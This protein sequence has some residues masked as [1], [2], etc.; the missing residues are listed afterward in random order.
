MRGGLLE[1][2]ERN[3]R[4]RSPE[5]GA[6][7]AAGHQEALRRV[8]RHILD[9]HP[10]LL[11]EARRR[12]EGRERLR[13]AIQNVI[14]AES[15]VV[16]KAAR[17][18][19]TEYILNEVTGLGPIEPLVQDEDITEIMVNG[20]Q[21]VWVETGGKMCRSSAC[22]KDQEQL[23]EVIA[24]AIAPLGR[25]IDQSVPFV[26][27]RLPDGSRLHACIPPVSLKGPILSIRKFPKTGF[28]LD[29]LVRL[30]SVG[31]ECAEFLRECVKVRLN[32]IV[33]GGT[34]SGKTSTLNALLS[35]VKNL[36]Q[37]VVTIEDCAELNPS[38]ENIVSLES[39]PANIEGKGEITIRMLVRN[40]LRT[41]P[42]RIV[43]G[44]VRG[45]EAFDMLQ[46]MNTGHQGSMSTVHANGSEDAL[47][48][49][50][51]MASL[52]PEVPDRVVRELIPAAVD[53]VIF[54]RRLPTGDRKLTAVSL[55]SKDANVRGPRLIPIFESPD[56]GDHA[57]LVRSP[58]VLPS[59]YGERAK[60]SMV[61]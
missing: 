11:G 24:R 8:Q 49:L 54:Q 46:A 43:I 12:E 14:A 27:G 57:D 5:P 58:H 15:L 35:E 32:I 42:D 29:D 4:Q 52:A 51:G 9:S 17:E 20:C 61:T 48:R 37:R 2:L 3:G 44:E 1:R 26:D 13:A 22:F 41:R 23:L 7:V 40:A 60:W 45:A 6:Q 50:E 33:A 10:M 30:R 28:V 47:K 21:E 36:G 31:E 39:R 19:L 53:A 55:M 16:G 34:G 25:R 18:A 59:W 56:A 38:V